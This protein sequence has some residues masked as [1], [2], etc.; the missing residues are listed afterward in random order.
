MCLSVVVSLS[1][2]QVLESCLRLPRA[3]PAKSPRFMGQGK[4]HNGWSFVQQ[5]KSNMVIS[6]YVWI[7]GISSQPV[8]HCQMQHDTHLAERARQQFAPGALTVVC[9]APGPQDCTSPLG[10]TALATTLDKVLTSCQGLYWFA[11]SHGQSCLPASTMAK[12]ACV[13]NPLCLCQML[14]HSWPQP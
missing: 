2:L 8:D 12:Q 3:P 14:C 7:V 11:L 4:L 5:T 13:Y 10:L 9:Q 6:S 1:A